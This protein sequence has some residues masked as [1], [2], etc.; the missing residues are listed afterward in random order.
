MIK[1]SAR[2]ANF[3]YINKPFRL[4][5][6]FFS[7]KFSRKLN[8]ESVATPVLQKINLSLSEGDR[9]GVIGL[10]G[11]GKSSLLRSISDS[12]VLLDGSL[13]VV[14]DPD[15]LLELGSVDSDRISGETAASNFFSVFSVLLGPSSN[16]VSLN[17]YI[18]RVKKF[19]ELGDSFHQPIY[20]YSS[21]MK[22]RLLYSMRVCSSSLFKLVDEVLSV[23]D[24]AFNQK[25]IRQ[26]RRASK[27]QYGIFVS[28]DWCTLSKI[29]NKWLW[30]ESGRIHKFGSSKDVLASYLHK[31]SDWLQEANSL[32]GALTCLTKSITCSD[33]ATISFRAFSPKQLSFSIS[34][35]FE[36]LDGSQGFQHVL[37]TEYVDISLS[38]EVSQTKAHEFSISFQ[39][40]PLLPCVQYELSVAVKWQDHLTKESQVFTYGWLNSSGFQLRLLPE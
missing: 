34:L 39:I 24:N 12:L 19:S 2:N 5:K 40:P 27:S 7:S 11:S 29:C 21:G 4:L 33:T 35:S 30:L 13:S 18:F 38:S 23:G 10:N 28:H 31:Y 3:G 17:E 36:I 37:L 32:F 14:E 1:V 25:C 26:L 15:L 8:Y 22:A 20:T 6:L 9:I 16:S